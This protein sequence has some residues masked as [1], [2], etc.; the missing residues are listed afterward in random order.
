M[1]PLNK[2]EQWYYIY[3][4]RSQGPIRIATV[5]REMENGVIG[6]DTFVWRE[7]MENWARAK[8]T[9]LISLAAQFARSAR[10]GLPPQEPAETTEEPVFSEKARSDEEKKYDFDDLDFD[11]LSEEQLYYLSEGKKMSFLW[12]M[13]A[14][15]S[16]LTLYSLL[17]SSLNIF[18]VLTAFTLKAILL[19]K[20]WNL[21]Q[22]H[23]PQATPG[24]AVL[25]YLV[26]G[27]NL[28]G[29]FVAIYG[30]S[31]DINKYISGYNL[32]GKRPDN[33]MALIYC[34]FFVFVNARDIFMLLFSRPV[35][36]F[37]QIT[38]EGVNILSQNP[39]FFTLFLYVA[40]TFFEIYVF[41]FLTSGG[42]TIAMHKVGLKR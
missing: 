30:L 12:L 20:C 16:V 10:V 5:L 2:S 15:F 18:F 7:G 17:F 23:G 34:I 4:K 1:D 14:A 22:E 9:E 31:Q 32:N 27:L 39:S 3:K 25:M 6:P 21:L 24:M 29:V 42:L 36:E 38:E 40:F 11:L 41:R 26:P 8:D 19:Y 33:T 28:Y 37:A 35:S 13:F